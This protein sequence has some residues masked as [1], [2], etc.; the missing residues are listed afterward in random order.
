M[1]PILRGQSPQANNFGEYRDAFPHLVSRVGPYCVYCERRIQT[2][3]AVEHIQPKGLAQYAGLVG[4]WDNFLLGCINCN[5]TKKDK[6]VLLE[7]TFL[8]DRDNTFAAFVYTQ[9][10]K[11]F[12][13]P[14]LSDAY[15]RM[16]RDTLA[17]TGLDKRLNEVFDENG[18]LVAIDRVGQRMEAWLVAE[19]SLAELRATPTDAMRRQIVRTAIRTGSFSIW[20]QVFASDPTTR[21]MLIDAFPGTA[22]D[23]FD[24]QTTSPV[25][26]RP[27]NG[28][29][30]AGKI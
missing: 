7:R 12:P 27:P 10:G 26:P 21:R 17:L 30:H 11:V 20:M 19:E 28:L 22:K 29:A 1:R 23:C 3:L 8:P 4:R 24:A 15:A 5:G 14:T 6:D 2:G 18:K 9:D 13:S 25:S 16:A